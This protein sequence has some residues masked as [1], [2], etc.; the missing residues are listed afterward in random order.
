MI[1]QPKLGQTV[2]LWWCPIH[3]LTLGSPAVEKTKQCHEDVGS[4]GEYAPC[5]ESVEGPF[6]AV[7]L[8]RPPAPLP[9]T[10]PDPVEEHRERERLRQEVRVP[11]PYERTP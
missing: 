3:H 2:E 4:W 1:D 8:D 5:E 11:L 7:I 6:V 10:P 9:P